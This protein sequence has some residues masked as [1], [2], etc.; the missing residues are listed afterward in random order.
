MSQ[1]VTLKRKIST[2]DLQEALDHIENLSMGQEHEWGFD[3]DY[4]KDSNCLVTF[5]NGELEATSPS[6]ELFIE[7]EALA[8]Q[9]GAEIV[10]ED[11]VA[12]VHSGE[13]RNAGREIVLFW[14]IVVLLLFGMLVWRW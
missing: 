10:L 3:L 4:V 5:A 11:D 13:A 6:D 8:A 12:I 2:A 1:V 9:L 7:L 14:P